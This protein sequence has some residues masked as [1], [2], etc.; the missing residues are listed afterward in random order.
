MV[1]MALKE[2]CEGTSW[3]ILSEI[4]GEFGENILILWAMIHVRILKDQYIFPEL[5]NNLT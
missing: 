3:N 5:T 2:N 1:K 4:I